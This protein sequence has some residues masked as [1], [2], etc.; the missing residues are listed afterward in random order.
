MTSDDPE[1]PIFPDWI[2]GEIGAEET[3]TTTALAPNMLKKLYRLLAKKDHNTDGLIWTS[4][5]GETEQSL[6]TLQLTS[7]GD[8]VNITYPLDA[9]IAEAMQRYQ[10]IT[11]TGQLTNNGENSGTGVGEPFITK[12]ITDNLYF[13][14]GGSLKYPYSTTIDGTAVDINSSRLIL[15]D[16]NDKIAIGNDNDPGLA[17]IVLGKATQV[18][19]NLAVNGTINST[20]ISSA[21]DFQEGGTLLKN[22]YSPQL[23]VFMTNHV[24]GTIKVSDTSRTKE[25]GKDTAH[26]HV[27]V[28]KDG[29]RPL[30]VVGYN[31][32]YVNGHNNSDALYANV[33]ECYL[34]LDS[35]GNPTN[36]VEYS[37]Y[38]IAN[39]E[40][41]VQ[42]QIYVLYQKIL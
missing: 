36:T 28:A 30:G 10:P 19:G 1:E 25:G 7:G 34:Q 6:G 18:N 15:N 35:L 32:N 2:I 26:I 33:W 31:V 37:I 3:D 41:Y 38:N 9:A 4:A 13:N 22:K 8:A 27:N 40:I 17:G 20:D 29:W 39:R 21:P 42:I 12:Y 5:G 16:A 14:N 11:H 24:T 23:K